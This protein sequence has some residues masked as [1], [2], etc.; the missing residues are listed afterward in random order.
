MIVLM[1]CL[2]EEK[3]VN[4]CIGDFHDEE[5]VDRIIVID[6]CSTDYT[7]QELL[8]FDKVEVYQHAW[9]D[10]YHDMEVSQSNIALSYIPHNQI[11]M[12]LDFDEKMSDDLKNILYEIEKGIFPFTTDIAHFSRRT[13]EPIRYDGTPFAMVGEDNWPIESHQIGQYPDYQC[14]LIRKNPN[15]RWINSPHHILIG[16]ESNQNIDADIIHYEK[17]DLRD[18][19]RIEKKWLRTQV[20]RKELGLSPDVFQT[21]IKPELHKFFDSSYWRNP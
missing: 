11:A 4:R 20:R 13:I 12:I 16:Y 6:G 1:K 2:D 8:Q 18:R 21:T 10:S 5:W 9:I 14:R 3:Y 17:D 7:I 19:E 15:L